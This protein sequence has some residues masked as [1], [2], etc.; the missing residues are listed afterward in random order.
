[1]PKDVAGVMHE[2]KEGS[3]RGRHTNRRRGEAHP[4][5]KGG[6]G[7]LTKPCCTCKR[8]L[9]VSEFWKDKHSHDGYLSQCKECA[10]ETHKMFLKARPEYA[11]ERMHKQALAKLGLTLADYNRM[12]DEQDGCCAICKE[13]ES[14]NKNQKLS[15]DHC[16]ESGVFRGLLCN[17][18]NRAMGLFRDDPEILEAAANYLRSHALK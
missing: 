9:P 15:A 10:Y 12:Y 18:C 13:P 14:G 1:M 16:H 3:Q 7:R 2:F 11:A 17:R 5:W 4:K 6:R 8:E